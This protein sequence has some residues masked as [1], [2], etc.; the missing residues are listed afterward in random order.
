M[1]EK[2]I[3]FALLR[4]FDYQTGSLIVE[5]ACDIFIALLYKRNYPKHTQGASGLKAVL[6]SL[7]NSK[8]ADRTKGQLPSKAR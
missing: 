7:Q 6:A 3:W 8:L 1:G 5:D 2:K 4:S